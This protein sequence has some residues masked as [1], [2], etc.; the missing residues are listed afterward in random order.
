MPPLNSITHVITPHHPICLYHLIRLLLNLV[1]SHRTLV[2]HPLAQGITPL[3][4]MVLTC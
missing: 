4:L 1:L 2:V 3:Q